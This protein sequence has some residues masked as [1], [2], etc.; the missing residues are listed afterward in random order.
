[1]L[2]ICKLERDGEQI[3]GSWYEDIAKR[4]FLPAEAASP[5]VPSNRY[6][7]F[8]R[9]STLQR[10]SYEWVLANV[11]ECILHK[12][13]A[14]HA[15]QQGRLICNV[16]VLLLKRAILGRTCLRSS[17]VLEL[18]E[19]PDVQCWLLHQIFVL[20]QISVFCFFCVFL[21]ATQPVIV[22][23]C[24]ILEPFQSPNVQCWMCRCYIKISV[25]AFQTGNVFVFLDAT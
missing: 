19:S 4:G 21:D 1:M 20:H 7:M 6:V 13:Q 24:T 5:C 17:F 9:F 14:V 22:Q 18:F 16:S 25:F 2:Q 15:K 11:L 3:R 12:S 10:F 8:H 23:L